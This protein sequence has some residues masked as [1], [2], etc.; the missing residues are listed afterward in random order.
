MLVAHTAPPDKPAHEAGV[1]ITSQSGRQQF[2]HVPVPMPVRYHDSRPSSQTPEQIEND[3]GP[4]ALDGTRLWFGNTFY[5]G[6]GISGVGAIGSFDT[7]TRQFEMRYL[8]EIAPWSASALLV[9]G[10]DIW[11]GLRAPTTPAACCATT[12]ATGRS[13]HTRFAT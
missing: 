12:A 9:E 13:L 1:Y 3:I 8:P 10:P 4:F 2:F 6:E 5:D 11:V 7:I